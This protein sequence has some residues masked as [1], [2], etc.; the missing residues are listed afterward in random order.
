MV[1]MS[2]ESGA[3][4]FLHQLD[5]RLDEEYLE[6]SRT[7]INRLFVLMRS[8]AMHDLSNEALVRPFA[9]LEETVRGYFARSSDSVEVALVDGNFFI[10]GRL[11]HLDFSTYENTRHLRRVFEFIGIDELKFLAPPSQTELSRF[12]EAFVISLGDRTKSI[13]TVDLGSIQAGVR[14]VS[15]HGELYGQEDPRHHVLGVYASGLL[16]LRQFV[17]DLR[18]GKAPRYARIK[19]LCLQLIDLEPRYHNLLVALI[20]LEGYKGNLFCHMLNTA[21]LAIAFGHRIGLNRDQLL[22]LGM[23]G[24]YHDLGWALLGTLDHADGNDV[25]LTIDGINRIKDSARGQT[26]ELRVK[27]ARS[28]IRIGGFNELIISRLIVAYET[29]IPSTVRPDGLY[30]GDIDASFMTHVIRMAAIYDSLTT[31]SAGR[32]ALRPDQAMKKIMDDGGKTHNPFLAKLFANSLGYY[33]V[34][35][36]VELD[37]SEIGLVVNLPRDPLNF[38]RPQVKLMIDRSGRR[39]EDGPVVDLSDVNRSGRYQRTVDRAYD[40]RPFGVSI[41]N[42]FFGDDE[43]IA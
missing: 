23:S 2:Q 38:D 7:L 17:N 8:A 20:H 31:A 27:V 21:V 9:Q 43:R 35:T 6:Q 28:L 5:D 26:D 36:L 25:N 12:I 34:G 39:I 42:F 40:G 29:Q 15:H 32:S 10:N 37:S 3:L 14:H 33:P 22:E 41:T 19:R 4:D 18:K 24:F 1:E 13:S 30:Y 11:L 16:M